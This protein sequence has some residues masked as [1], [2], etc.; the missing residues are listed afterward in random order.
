MAL[1]PIEFDFKSLKSV[2]TG[3]KKSAEDICVTILETSSGQVFVIDKT[4]I[5]VYKNWAYMGLEYSPVI[6]DV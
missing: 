6:R 4:V 1:P 3:F 5:K 2:T